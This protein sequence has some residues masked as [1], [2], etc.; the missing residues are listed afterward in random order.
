MEQINTCKVLGDWTAAFDLND[1]DKDYGNSVRFRILDYVIS[2]IAGL[3]VNNDY[4]HM[5]ERVMYG[6]GGN[7]Q[8]SVLFCEKKYLPGSG[9]YECILW[10]WGRP[11]RWT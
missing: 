6:F 8:S 5:V 9:L 7:E 1:T 2:A 10:T 3:K 4:N 11:G